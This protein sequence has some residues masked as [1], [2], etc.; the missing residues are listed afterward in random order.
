MQAD[1][2]YIFDVV[3]LYFALAIYHYYRNS[4]IYS[5]VSSPDASSQSF[6]ETGVLVR[7]RTFLTLHLVNC[8][9]NTST[10]K[11]SFGV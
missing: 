9:V 7:A 5:K 11:R 3:V 4:I 1:V 8:R 10:A 6:Q 2:S